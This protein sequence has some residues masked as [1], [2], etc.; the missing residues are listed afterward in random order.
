[1]LQG[2]E[3]QSSVEFKWLLGRNWK[4]ATRPGHS[5]KYHGSEYSTVMGFHTQCCSTTY[6]RSHRS[7]PSSQTPQAFLLSLWV[8]LWIPFA[9]RPTPVTTP[10][11][12]DDTY[13][14]NS[15][16]GCRGCLAFVWTTES[17]SSGTDQSS[18]P[19][20]TFLEHSVFKEGWLAP[21]INHSL[22][23]RRFWTFHPGWNESVMLCFSH[24]LFTSLASRSA[25]TP[26]LFPPCLADLLITLSVTV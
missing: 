15:S 20:Y 5:C 9:W 1:M 12:V 22:M 3:K 17:S 24:K 26:H 21:G 7:P 10:I 11:R 4:A 13:A 23:G 2:R 18:R 14:R 19:K 25:P 8:L 6:Q 16:Q